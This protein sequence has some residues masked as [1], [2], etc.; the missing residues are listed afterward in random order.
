MFGAAADL[1]EQFGAADHLVEAAAAE[2]GENLAHF[3]GDEGHQVDDLLRA[4]GE[5]GAQLLVLGA[6]ADRASVR[7]SLARPDTAHG[8]QADSP[9]ALFLAPQS[10]RDTDV[11]GSTS[12]LDRA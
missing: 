4:A 3:L 8:D 12:G 7:L 10:G 5:L 9:A 1:A 6:D 2:L 11:S